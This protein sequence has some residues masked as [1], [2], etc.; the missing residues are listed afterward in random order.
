MN[1]WGKYYAKMLLLPSF[2]LLLFCLLFARQFYKPKFSTADSR[3]GSGDLLSK[4]Q[5]AAYARQHTIRS[6]FLRSIKLLSPMMFS[7]AVTL[8]TFLVSNSLSPFNCIS[9]YNE[10]TNQNIYIMARNPSQKCYDVQWNANLPFVVLFSV[11]YGLLFPCV[12][13]MT[14]FRH[15]K[16]IED[17]DFQRGY[18]SLI[19]L[20]RRS[21]F[22]WELLSMLKRA[23]FVV[24][25]EFLNSRQDSYLT[26]FAASISTMAFFSGVEAVYAP[27]A[28][29][30]LNLLSST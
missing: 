7:T 1:F 16:N 21:L 3:R 9:H 6:K 20:Y 29:K 15:R 14:F 12:V 28:T 25:T 17:P 10:F 27:Y 24:M 22:F 30:N 18:G 4:A 2:A 23:S 8:Y 11:A 13:S 26:K 19:S 5:A